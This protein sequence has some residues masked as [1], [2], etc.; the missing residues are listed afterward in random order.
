MKRNI[1]VVEK[2]VPFKGKLCIK[3][4]VKNK[5]VKWG[6][7]IFLLCGESGLSYNLYLFQGY[8]E[9]DPE[10]IKTYGSGGSVVLPLTE[11]IKPNRHFLIF[12]DYFSSYGLFEKLLHNKIYAV[13]TIRAN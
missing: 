3:K 10:N 12:D 4:Y 8:F 1:C 11:N 9:L 7:K 6:I 13:G 2:I 5:L